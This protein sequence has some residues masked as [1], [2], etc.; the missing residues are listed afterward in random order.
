LISAHRTAFKKDKN[1]KVVP[2][3]TL[4]AIDQVK[5]N[6]EIAKKLFEQ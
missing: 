5:R 2:Q 1:L 3:G 6:L 4:R